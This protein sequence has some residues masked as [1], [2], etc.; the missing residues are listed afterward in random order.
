MPFV[1]VGRE[2]SGSIDLYY[3]DHGTGKPVVLIHSWPLSG[4]AWERQMAP[5]LEAGYRVITYD[6]RGFGQSSQPWTGYEY[7]TLTADLHQLVTH[8][9]LDDATLVGLSMGGGEVA[10]YPSAYGQSRVSKV[11][12]IA[13]IPPCLLKRPDNPEGVDLAVFDGVRAGIA[14]DRFAF[15]A[16]FLN[17]FYNVDVLG[18]IRISDEAVQRSW[19]I[20]AGSS[21]KGMYDLVA[22]WGTDFRADLEKIARPALIIHGDSDRIVPLAVSGQRTHALIQGSE[23]TVIEGG[24][25]GVNWT[26]AEEV[27]RALLEFLAR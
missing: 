6:R 3:E 23:L 4:R 16:G 19:Q 1:S 20:G 8:L 11:V 15:L 24:P 2:N 26:H 10:R 17:S 13:A 21:P 12:F 22:A 27:N 14:K 18:G 25:H 5:L 7:D 9:D